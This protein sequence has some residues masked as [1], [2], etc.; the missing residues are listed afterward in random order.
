M[1][2]GAAPFTIPQN[3]QAAVVMASL[4]ISSDNRDDYSMK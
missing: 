1:L 2:V 4:L 3:M